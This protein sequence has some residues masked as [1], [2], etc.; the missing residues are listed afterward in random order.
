MRFV[1]FSSNKGDLNANVPLTNNYAATTNPGVSNDVTQG[2]EVG[3]EW[4]NTSTGAVYKCVSAAAGAASWA[5][6]EAAGGALSGNS[7][8]VNGPVSISGASTTKIAPTTLAAVG[9]TQGNAALVTSRK[10]V[11]SASL[12]TEGVKLPVWATGLEV[13]LINGGAIPPKVWPNTGAKIAANATN[14]AD[15]TKL[16]A[17]KDTVYKAVGTNLWIPFRGA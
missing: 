7:L 2:Y 10:V 12:S 16:A 3:S 1:L 6:Q 8:A 14:A 13:D 11:V 5:L 15:A 9:A 17:F 4:I